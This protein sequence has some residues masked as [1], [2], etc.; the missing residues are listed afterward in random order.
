MNKWIVE[1]SCL[2]YPQMDVDEADEE[3]EEEELNFSGK[4]LMKI[5][6]AVVQLVQSLLRLLQTF[7]L[8]DRPQS[9]GSFTQVT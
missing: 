5:R 3:E 1:G 9:A 8:N 7:P 2:C 4:D 6:E